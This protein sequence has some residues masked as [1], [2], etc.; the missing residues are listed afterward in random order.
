MDFVIKRNSWYHELYM[1]HYLI[2]YYISQSDYLVC[3]WNGFEG[4]RVSTHWTNQYFID[5]YIVAENSYVLAFF[6]NLPVVVG[7]L[8]N[9]LW[10]RRGMTSVWMGVLQIKWGHY[11]VPAMF[12]IELMDLPVGHK[13]FNYNLFLVVWSLE[14]VCC[15]FVL[16]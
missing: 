9:W 6:C 12:S 1:F 11:L 13:V 7:W 2:V 15:D 4:W 8:M 16:G 5:H 3:F 10:W 14:N